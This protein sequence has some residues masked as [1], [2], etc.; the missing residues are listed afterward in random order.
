MNSLDFALE[1]PTETRKV[2]DVT[3]AQVREQSR[4]SGRVVIESNE[5]RIEVEPHGTIATLVLE[6]G[7]PVV[8][9]EPEFVAKPAKKPKG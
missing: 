7:H 4:V 9:A 6:G 5:V 3:G 8:K 1:G 2:N